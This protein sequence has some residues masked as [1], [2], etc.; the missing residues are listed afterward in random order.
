MTKKEVK[1]KRELF[2]S[3]IIGGIGWTIL[4]GMACLYGAGGF[5]LLVLVAGIGMLL[6]AVPVYRDYHKIRNKEEK[7]QLQRQH[8][9][10]QQ[11]R[12]KRLEKDIEESR[13]ALAFYNKCKSYGV[14]EA[15]ANENEVAVIAETEGVTS[16]KEALSLYRKGLQANEAIQKE[17]RSLKH[18]EEVEQEQK[19]LSECPLD[20]I[21]R[22]KYL[23]QALIDIAGLSGQLDSLSDMKDGLSSGSVYM[24]V[25]KKSVK[26]AAFKGQLV[27]GPAVGVAAALEAQRNNQVIDKAAQERAQA[28]ANNPLVRPG[29]QI[30]K[31]MDSAKFKLQYAQRRVE[32]LQK[33]LVDTGKTE[34]LFNSLN[35][36]IA[37]HWITEGGNLQ[38]SIESSY[39]ARPMILNKP[40]VIDGSVAIKAFANGEAIGETFFCPDGFNELNPSKIEGFNF[41]GYR[42]R[43]IELDE[44]KDYSDAD[45][46]FEIK[47]IHLWIM[48]S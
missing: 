6:F 34:E 43:L 1:K 16:G 45:I 40:A 46:S 37:R 2:Y 18:I 14:S 31:A 13:R 33:R 26:A 5:G 3:L 47:P 44:N 4:G 27:G 22:D 32:Q 12:K 30:D 19:L 8:E 20:L 41:I 38:I 42:L 15:T 28:S 7:R 9:L 39:T 10:A 35:I 24:P 36:K 17:T 29:G 21:G 25:K 23:H 11:N 48:E